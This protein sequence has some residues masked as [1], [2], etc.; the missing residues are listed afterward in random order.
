MQLKL[1]EKELM[2]INNVRYNC[3]SDFRCGLFILRNTDA[4]IVDTKKRT[5]RNRKRVCQKGRILCKTW[6]SY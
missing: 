5:K 3:Y 1:Q 6:D 2:V 4:C